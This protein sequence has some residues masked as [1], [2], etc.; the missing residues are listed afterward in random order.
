M[1][2]HKNI[3]SITIGL[4]LCLLLVGFFT[5]FVV[6][7]QTGQNNNQSLKIMRKAIANSVPPARITPT[8]KELDDAATP[9]IEYSESFNNQSARQEKN[10]RYNNYNLVLSEPGGNVSEISTDEINPSD[11]PYASSDAVLE[12]VV[13]ESR[14][15]LSADKKAVYSEYT[16]NVKD[17]HK[18]TNDNR[19]KKHESLVVDRFGGRVRYPNGQI[20]RYKVFGQGSPLVDGKYLL[21]LKMNTAGDYR[22]VTGYQM[23]GNKVLTL[24]GSRINRRGLGKSPVDKH[25]GK[26]IQK[27]KE[28]FEEAKEK[29]AS[30]EPIEREG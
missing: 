25:N 23:Q 9:I 4:A 29:P 16:V 26:D 2:K 20:V 11:L 14:A 21:F 8:D 13:V 19:I 7:S 30:D 24:D 15:Y 12:G 6:K 3:F 5:V 22:I 17:I 10:A 28:D 1:I 18:N 27:F